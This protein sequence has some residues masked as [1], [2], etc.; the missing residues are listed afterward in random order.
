MTSRTLTHHCSLHATGPANYPRV[1]AEFSNVDIYKANFKSMKATMS[2]CDTRVPIKPILFGS[3]RRT[4]VQRPIR[5]DTIPN[6]KRRIVLDVLG[7][8]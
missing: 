5:P 4:P 6:V 2:D 8:K 1:R 7:N 3:T